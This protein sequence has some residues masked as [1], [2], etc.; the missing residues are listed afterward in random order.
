MEEKK[1]WKLSAKGND[2]TLLQ[3]AYNYETDMTKKKRIFVVV[4]Y[5]SLA[6]FE[7][8]DDERFMRKK[9]TCWLWN[10]E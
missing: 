10:G 6:E 9:C 2:I 8:D 4:R 7:S 1:R 3:K 5:R